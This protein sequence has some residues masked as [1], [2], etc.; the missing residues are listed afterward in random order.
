MEYVKV[1]RVS[2]VDCNYICFTSKAPNSN[3]ST[4]YIFF[5]MI[6]RPP[7]STL[8][9]YTTLFRSRRPSPGSA[10]PRPGGVGPRCRPQPH[11]R[12]ACAKD[13]KARANAADPRQGSLEVFRFGGYLRRRP[14]TPTPP[15]PIVRDKS[16]AV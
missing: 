10:T 15:G 5:L 14:S 1:L 12:S 2:L 16:I 6:R 8:F 11:T 13:A 4:L 3:T 9:P 7:R